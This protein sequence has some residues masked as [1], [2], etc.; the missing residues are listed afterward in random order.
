MAALF[1]AV[2]MFGASDAYGQR[3][4]TLEWSGT[5]DQDVQ[6]VIRGRSVTTRT[7]RGQRYRDDRHFFRG[8]RGG[9]INSD[10]DVDKLD[11]RGKVRVI[12]QPNRRNRYTTIIRI[13]DPKGGA[14]RYRIRVEWD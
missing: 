4:T 3:Q 2:F 10:V 8:G 6:I 5:V 13:E 1:A 12:Q 14:D 7:L 11:G 9:N